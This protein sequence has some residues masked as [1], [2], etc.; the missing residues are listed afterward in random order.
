MPSTAMSGN[1][2]LLKKLSRRKVKIAFWFNQ[3]DRLHLRIFLVDSCTWRIMNGR[4]SPVEQSVLSFTACIIYWREPEHAAFWYVPISAGASVCAEG[5]AA[6]AFSVSI[7]RRKRANV[8]AFRR[9]VLHV[10]RSRA[11]LTRTLND[12]MF[13]TVHPDDRETFRQKPAIPSSPKSVSTTSSIAQACLGTMIIACCTWLVAISPCRMVRA[14]PFWSTT[15][16]MIRRTTNCARSREQSPQKSRFFDEKILARWQ[17]FHKTTIACSTTTRRS[18]VCC[19]QSSHT[20]PASPSTASFSSGRAASAASAGCITQSMRARA[21]RP[22]RWRSERLR[23]TCSPPALVKKPRMWSIS[24]SSSRT[25]VRSPSSPRRG[26]CAPR[27]TPRFFASESNGLDFHDGAYKG[28]RVWNLTQNIS[29][30][31]AGCVEL[32]PATGAEATLERYLAHIKVF[33]PK[34]IRSLSFPSF[35]ARSC[36]CSLKAAPI[37]ARLPSHLSEPREEPNISASLRHDALARQRRPFHENRRGKRHRDHNHRYA[38][39]QDDILLW[40]R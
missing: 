16:S 27:S 12:D 32:F 15:T 14:S 18:R 24:T 40:C 37:R 3:R 4:C 13:S 2:L 20:T 31:Q 22:I 33:A 19:R 10:R 38:G 34:R 35:R 39:D 1:G 17:S 25:R 21:S 30:Y 28:F 36:C 6:R 23:S 29:S 5:A 11:E 7:C 9:H 8:A 26:T